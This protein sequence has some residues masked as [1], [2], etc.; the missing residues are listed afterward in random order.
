MGLLH[1][2]PVSWNLIASL[3]SIHLVFEELGSVCVCVCV[4]CMRVRSRLPGDYM[5]L[6]PIMLDTTQN[7][8]GSC[9]C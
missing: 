6:T 2:H 5:P 9:K 7:V 8:L 1:P 4:V 3:T